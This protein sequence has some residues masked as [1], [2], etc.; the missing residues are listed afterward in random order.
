[1]PA[2]L[3]IDDMEDQT[4][5]ISGSDSYGGWYVYDDETVGAHMTPP[6]S[7]P[8]TMEPIPGGRC[9]SE[10]AMRLSG[11]GF[12]DWGAGMGFD[13]GYGSSTVNRRSS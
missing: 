1:M 5:G 13:F 12:S 4:Q 2:Q 7:T 9:A 10:Y 3:V 6:P 8:F 11:T